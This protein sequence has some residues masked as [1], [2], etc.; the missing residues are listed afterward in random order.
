MTKNDVAKV[1]EDRVYVE[2][3]T[4]MLSD[5]GLGR[6]IAEA[7]RLAMVKHMVLKARDIQ[8]AVEAE[9]STT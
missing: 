5:G 6:R 3:V 7:A 8:S 9:N 1:K 4:E 2:S